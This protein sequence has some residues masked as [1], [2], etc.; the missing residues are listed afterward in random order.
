[1]S[2]IAR[3]S[4]GK[5]MAAITTLVGLFAKVDAKVHELGCVALQHGAET[6]DARRMLDVY[7]AF[8]HS[9]RKKGFLVWVE[10]F[11]PIRITDNDKGVTVKL[12]KK[13]DK[14]FTDW[15]VEGAFARPFW[16]LEEAAERTAKP[17]SA[18]AFLKVIYAYK[19]KLTKAK[20]ENKYPIEGDVTQLETLI[21]NVIVDATRRKA[22]I[23]NPQPTP[24]PKAKPRTRK[25]KAQVPQQLAA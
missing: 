8:G 5:W 4:N 6:F 13:E 21:D 7:K 3:M 22:Q 9:G 12:A 20:E 14:G 24:A 16:T 23:D 19:G 2:N 10:M 17:L 25:A 11:S 15:D 1:M 18:D